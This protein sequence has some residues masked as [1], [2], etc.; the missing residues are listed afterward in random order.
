MTESRCD[1]NWPEWCSLS[2]MTKFNQNW[3]KEMNLNMII[4]NQEQLKSTENT[5]R[6]LWPILTKRGLIWTNANKQAKTFR[7]YHIYIWPRTESNL[8]QLWPISSKSDQNDYVCLKMSKSDWSTYVDDEWPGSLGLQTEKCSLLLWR[9][10]NFIFQELDYFSCLPFLSLSRR[11]FL[12][13]IYSLTHPPIYLST[14]SSSHSFT[15]SFVY[16][17]VHGFVCSFCLFIHSFVLLFIR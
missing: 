12:F 17:F 9:M 2:L 11:S 16:S 7:N 14:H 5:S 6:Q 15:H 1:Q 13:S 3:P 4:N 8:N 10:G